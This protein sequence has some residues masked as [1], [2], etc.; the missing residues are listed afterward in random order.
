MEHPQNSPT[1]AVTLH[2]PSA[3]PVSLCLPQPLHMML[4]PCLSFRLSSSPLSHSLASLPSLPLPHFLLPRRRHAFLNHSME[5]RGVS[6]LSA[7]GY[8][9][10]CI[11][12]A[13]Y[14]LPLPPMFSYSLVHTHFSVCKIQPWNLKWLLTLVGKV[15][16]E[17]K[18]QQQSL[19][20]Q[21]HAVNPLC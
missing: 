19:G 18:R 11:I 10:Y 1:L 8:T 6:R 21:T 9:E 12:I 3:N 13:L 15:E 14:L 7:R 16:W 4:W 20:T 17:E 5:N 2:S